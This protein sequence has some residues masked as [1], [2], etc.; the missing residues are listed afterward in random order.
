MINKV[1]GLLGISSKAGK[2]I[3]GTDIILEKMEKKKVKL[4]I[5]AEDASEKTIK[6]MK[7][8]CNKENV[9]L[10]IYGNILENSKAIGKHNRATIAIIDQNLANAIK[11]LI[12]GGE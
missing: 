1:Y 4:V 2:V 12:H 9:E 10:I 6:N 3:S 5:I 11:K 8:Y 7:Y